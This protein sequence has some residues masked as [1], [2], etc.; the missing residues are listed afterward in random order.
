MKDGTQCFSPKDVNLE[1]RLV[2][3]MS[4][5]ETQ[6]VQCEKLKVC[7]I[8]VGCADS[9][10]TDDEDDYYHESEI[11]SDIKDLEMNA[12]SRCVNGVKQDVYIDSNTGYLENRSGGGNKLIFGEGQESKSEVE[13]RND[14]NETKNI[15]LND[16]KPNIF[17]S[18]DEVFNVGFRNVSLQKKSPKLAF[19]PKEV[20]GIIESE[21]LLQKNAQSHTMRK[22]IVFSCLGIRHGCE[23]MYELDFNHFSILRKG[24]PLIS[25]ENPGVSSSKFVNVCCG[26]IL[27]SPRYDINSCMKGHLLT[28]SWIW[29][30][31]NARMCHSQL[32][33]F[34]FHLLLCQT[35]K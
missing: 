13:E 26:N 24:E 2:S 27:F 15:E 11:P 32:K 4:M 14:K 29:T 30:S 12:N 16:G 19:C 3:W 7:E 8:T 9:E 22:I 10:E 23:E 21:V 28:W 25:P 20:K 1:D 18:G 6:F 35:C 34:F 5:D 31:K 17:A 33:L